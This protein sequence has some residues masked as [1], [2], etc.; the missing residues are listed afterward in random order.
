MTA[1]PQMSDSDVCLIGGAFV[2]TYLD[3]TE[4]RSFLAHCADISA[5]LA[6]GASVEVVLAMQELEYTVRRHSFSFIASLPDKTKDYL[7]RLK[8]VSQPR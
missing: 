7:M 8:A 3:D 1:L 2:V 4:K 6:E 5:G